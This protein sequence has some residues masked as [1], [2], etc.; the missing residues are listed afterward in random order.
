MQPFIYVDYVSDMIQKARKKV[1]QG[2]Y[3]MPGRIYRSKGNRSIS[4][5]ECDR[6]FNSL[7]VFSVLAF[8]AELIT[9]E[10]MKRIIDNLDHL[11]Y[12]RD[13][14]LGVFWDAIFHCIES[15]FIFLYFIRFLIENKII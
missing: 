13:M 1:K 8:D 12:S 2:K 10:E 3:K 9:N 7:Y 4:K 14:E 6:I 5:Y 15:D 11:A